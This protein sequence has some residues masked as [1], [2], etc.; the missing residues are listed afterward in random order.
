MPIVFIHG[1]NNRDGSEYRDN[2]RARDAF[3]KELVVPELGLDPKK[4]KIFNP[5]W[6]DA[7]ITFRWDLAVVPTPSKKY[8]S[9]GSGDPSDNYQ[10]MQLAAQQ[11]G[12]KSIVEIAKKDLAA[13]VDLVFAAGIAAADSDKAAS[14][15]ARRYRAAMAYA[16]A[17]PKPAWLDAVT[18]DNFVDQLDA[19]ASQHGVESFGMGI[20]DSLKEGVSRLKNALPSAGT[21]L[22][23]R[24]WRKDLTESLARFTGDVFQYLKFRG[25]KDKR[26]EIPD[27]VVKALHE[28]A[29]AKQPGDDKLIVIAHSFGGEII[30]DILTHF[31]TNLEVDVLIT[32]GSQVGLFEEMKMFLASNE[33][34]GGKDIGKVPQPGKLKR[35]LNVFDT[36]DFVSYRAEPV[37]VGVQDFAYDTGFG[38]RT[39][40][41]GYF[42]Q[43]SFYDRLAARLKQP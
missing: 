25:D 41:S 11:A 5:Y 35:W 3:I 14:G 34:I 6:G 16:K 15:I 32:V 10:A 28:A 29:A 33:A 9:F 8:E 24:L 37:F 39:A 12:A 43:P 26:G 42:L 19:E 30:Y 2:V 21:D 36:N 18:D 40:H 27:R 17:S 22:A 31:D 20:M 13:A 7:G 1:V 23:A 4:V 38:G